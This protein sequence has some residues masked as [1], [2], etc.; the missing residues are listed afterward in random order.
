M[1]KVVDV[2]AGVI[3]R[4][5]GSFLL[6]Q[7]APG[8]FYP[9]Y[10]EFPGGKVEA[11]ET[12]AAAL[13]R[14]LDEEL[15]IR[16]QVLHPW[17]MREHHYEHAHVRLHFFEVPVWSGEINDHVH[18][19]LAWQ[20]ADHLEVAPMLPAN[21][22]ILKALRLPRTMGITH[23]GEIG[24]DAQL[25]ALDAALAD[26]LR[27]V[28]IREPGLD[29]AAR[30]AFAAEAVRRAQAAG[31]L[32]LVNGDVELALRCAADGVHLPAAQLAALGARP[33]LPWVGA[34]CHTRAELER[35]A[36][37][38]LDYAVLGAVRAT[39]THPDQPALG[40]E[41]F[42]ALAAE[43]PLPVLALGGLGAAD[44]AAARAAGAHGI[45]AIRGVWGAAR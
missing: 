2:S 11:G 29:A 6:G 26:G 9:G 10:W 21:G 23:A 39:P 14:E 44:M 4:P 20:R 37:L 28:Q 18:S 25:A 3:T 41:G 38:A 17:L 36:A 22:P 40:W 16:A 19:A 7:R 27:L 33:D 43:L 15:G 5:D 32:A 45:A 1:K 8:T 24:V 34:S 35:A 13:A 30:A 31:A 42:S 12:P